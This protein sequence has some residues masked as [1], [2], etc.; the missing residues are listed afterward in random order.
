MT[1]IMV[2]FLNKFLFV[3]QG[4]PSKDS[5]EENRSHSCP[6]QIYVGTPNNILGYYVD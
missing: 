5:A 2:S 6:D 3:Q 1:N 4:I